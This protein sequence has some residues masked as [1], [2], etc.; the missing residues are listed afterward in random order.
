[1]YVVC[2]HVVINF[3]GLFISKI[4]FKTIKVLSLEKFFYALVNV[5]I[6]TV[7]SINVLLVLNQ[8]VCGIS[9]PTSINDVV[10][11]FSSATLIW[12]P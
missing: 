12:D 9:V 10:R 3:S 6:P 4:L 7:F 1:M 11:F 2:N 8:G 5:K